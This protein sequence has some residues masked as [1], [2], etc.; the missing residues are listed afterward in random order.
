VA[1]E[2]VCTVTVVRPPRL[3]GALVRED[4][5]AGK[6]DAAEAQSLFRF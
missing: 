1:A 5:N 4:G 2:A 6:P 3:A